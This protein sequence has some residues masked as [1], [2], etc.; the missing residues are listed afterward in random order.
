MIKDDFYSPDMA[1]YQQVYCKVNWVIPN[2]KFWTS[3]EQRGFFG[4]N[5]KFF[6]GRELF[7]VY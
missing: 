2:A 1:I 7:C 4:S 3:Q 6:F 5:E